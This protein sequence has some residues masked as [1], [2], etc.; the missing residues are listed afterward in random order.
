MKNKIEFIYLIPFAIYSFISLAGGSELIQLSDFVKIVLYGIL[1]LLYG[2]KIILDKN[3]IKCLILYFLVALIC[4]YAYIETQTIFFFIN[5]LTIIAIKNVDVKKV[6]KIDLIMKC[7]F[8]A[9]HSLLYGVNYI[10]NYDGISNLI[11]ATDGYRVR[12]ALFFT[13]PNIASGIIF[14][15]IIDVFYLLKPIKVKYAIIST[16]IILA[17]YFITKSRT[18]LLIYM[19]FLILY[20]L[21]KVFHNLKY[22]KLLTLGQRYGIEIFSIFSF[23]LSYL[24]KFGNTIVYFINDLTSGR[25]YNS[26]VAINKFGMHIFPNAQANNLEQLFIIDNF[27][28]RCAILYGII[29]LILLIILEKIVDKNSENYVFEKIIFIVLCFSLFSEYYGIIIGNAIPL[30]ILGDIV[31]NRKNK[32]SLISEKKTVKS[33]L[34]NDLISIIIPVYNVKNY[35]KRCIES[36]CKQTYKNIE[37]ILID[38]GSSD[39]SEIICD[40]YAKKDNRIKVVHINNLGVSKARNIGLDTAKGNYITF[41]DADDYVSELYIEKMYELCTSND[42]DI[43]IIGTMELD[44]ETNKN[45]ESGYSLETNLNGTDALAEMFNEKYYFGCVWA[46]I[47]RS[48]LW[49]NNYFNEKTS[50][51]EDLEVLYNIFLES[52]KVSINTNERLYYYTKNRNNSAT[53]SEY[54]EKWEKEIEICERFVTDCLENHKR[55]F[56][57]ALKRYVR[58]N[59]SCILKT[60]KSNQNNEEVYNKLKNNIMKY[61]SYNIYNK[62]NLIMKLKILLILNFKPLIIKLLKII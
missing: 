3:S 10:F 44:E 57:F 6:V 13:H 58:I 34:N 42:S 21:N 60:L 32:N 33:S 22:K 8:I 50:I 49:N 20:Y 29:F 61:K 52:D 7:I 54:N 15:A 27:Y 55:I 1:I 48:R 43:A 26:Y 41:V 37:I 25:I 12:N 11:M 51:G 19:L 35:L 17:T 47:Y 14:W 16:L 18:T 9:S 30:L 46:K 31:I 62:F 23:A 40:D 38:D 36:L 24:Y 2:V 59:Y 45:Y 53:K 28:V 39:G 4:I 5:F 56:P